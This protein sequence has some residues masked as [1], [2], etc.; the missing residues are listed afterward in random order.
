MCCGPISPFLFGHRNVP[1]ILAASEQ[2][3]PCK[4]TGIYSPG[5]RE[6]HRHTP[7]DD[8][9]ERSLGEYSISA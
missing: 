8:L 3:L 5:L 1:C 4:Q 2:S 7:T 6:M 9:C